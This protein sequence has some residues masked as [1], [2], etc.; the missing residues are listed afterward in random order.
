MEKKPQH[1]YECRA[2]DWGKLCQLFTN[3]PELFSACPC[4]LNN[5]AP[6]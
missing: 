3:F 5:A 1:I 4:L 6:L 2:R